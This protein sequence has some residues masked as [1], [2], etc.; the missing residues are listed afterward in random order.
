VA[1]TYL[2]LGGI[3]G[4]VNAS[5]NTAMAGGQPSGVDLDGVFE[6]QYSVSGVSAPNGVFSGGVTA[7]KPA[8]SDLQTYMNGSASS[9][10]LWL[11]AAKSTVFP[12]ACVMVASNP[13]G[14]VATEWVKSYFLLKNATIT[15]LRTVTDD[16]SGVVHELGLA[17]GA[18]FTAWFATPSG[19]T[20]GARTQSGWDFAANVVWNGS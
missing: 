8:A 13:T 10:A 14:G 18:L 7:S 6:I 1:H 11:A 3:A 12:R 5:G 9:P 19:G 16:G 4:P 15:S 17:Y 20:L 2:K